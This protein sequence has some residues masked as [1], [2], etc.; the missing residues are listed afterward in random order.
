MSKE[1]NLRIY[2]R[3]H[4]YPQSISYY[5]VFLCLPLDKNPY[6]IN[7]WSVM[8]FG[9]QFFWARKTDILEKSFRGWFKK[10]STN[11]N[12][13]LKLYYQFEK[14]RKKTFEQTSKLKLIDVK[15]IDKEYLL[16][17]RFS[18]IGLA[19]DHLKYAEYTVDLFD[20]YVATIFKEKVNS[21]SKRELSAPDLATLVYPATLS[22]VAAYHKEILQL[23]LRRSAPK[24]DILKVVNKFDWVKM[25]WDGSGELTS[26]VVA[27]DV[28]LEKKKAMV[29]RRRE[30]N[31]LKLT[32]IKVKRE[33]KRILA[34]YKIPLARF[35]I[36]FDLLDKFNL[37][38]DYR[39]E[40]QMRT[41]QVIYWVL[42]EISRRFKI[43]FND[44]M[45]YENQEVKNLLLREQFV[46]EKIIKKRKQGM[47]WYFNSGK[48]YKYEGLRAKAVA[49]KLVWS[50][51]KNQSAEIKGLVAS[52]GK[53]KGR[54][55]V[56]KDAK[57]AN[58]KIVE[59]EILVTTMTLSD[60]LPAMKRAGAIVTDDGG[61]T[62]HAAIV[63]RELGK[64]CIVG[65][66]FATSIIK[67][68]DLI[69]VDAEYGVVR[70]LN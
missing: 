3:D 2:E 17:V 57:E 30:L 35:K 32:A 22:T 55:F 13:R 70:I 34:K 27:K 36:Y 68:G 20:D 46:L 8:S 64:P 47:L 24:V 59:G 38:H 33:R 58:A 54:A 48:L 51:H 10:W 52:K 12:A 44:L 43:A 4:L 61:A 63:S 39:K 42:R 37:Y 1:Y 31:D 21:L 23:S 18:A 50:H 53:C 69:E 28:A 62:C 49:E 67:N 40:I 9:D 15:K 65:T 41:N 6:I 16:K 26:D 11:K 19:V 29:A 14:D 56:T 7:R 25:S 5:L 66:K 60:A 45:Y